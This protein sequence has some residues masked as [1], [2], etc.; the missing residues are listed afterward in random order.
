MDFVSPQPGHG[1]CKMCKNG[2]ME[3]WWSMS[4]LR[5]PIMAGIIKKRTIAVK[6]MAYFF[7]DGMRR[8]KF[9]RVS[10]VMATG[11]H[12]VILSAHISSSTQNDKAR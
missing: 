10:Q 6:R 9:Q 11:Y 3:G 1:M 12:A 8:R 5:R 2:Q 7:I 4:G